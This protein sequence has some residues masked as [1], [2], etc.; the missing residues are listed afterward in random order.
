MAKSGA[1]DPSGRRKRKLNTRNRPTDA[2]LLDAARAVVAEQGGERVTMDMIAE[3]AGT[4]RVT[5]YAHFGSRDELL[6]R[7]I[8]RELDEFAAWMF[9]AYDEGLDMPFGARARHSVEATF[10]YARRN[11]EGLRVLLAHRQEAE[12]PGRRLYATLEPRVAAR[13]RENYA[14]RGANIAA[15]ADTLAS[16]MI[17]MSLDIAYRALIVDGADIDAACDLAV[18]ATLAVLRDVRPEQLLAIDASLTR[19]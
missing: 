15:S 17:G 12:D 10:E 11:P 14:T 13:L 9:A 19:P 3:H 8:V 1:A 5:L 4:T 7:V 18:T 16:L 2:E 6:E